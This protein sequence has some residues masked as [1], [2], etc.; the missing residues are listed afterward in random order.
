MGARCKYCLNN[1]SRWIPLGS[2]FPRAAFEP[3]HQD[4]GCCWLSAVHGGRKKKKKRTKYPG[5]T[6]VANSGFIISEIFS[7]YVEIV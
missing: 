7:S 4:I 3:E 6:D 1:L 2:A 5:V